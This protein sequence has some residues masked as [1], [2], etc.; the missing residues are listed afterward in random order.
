MALSS[1]LT[2]GAS[3]ARSFASSLRSRRP[4]RPLPAGWPR[5]LRLSMC[6]FR[7]LDQSL[8]RRFR[9]RD[10]ASRASRDRDLERVRDL[11]GGREPEAEAERE[12]E[13]SLGSSGGGCQIVPSWHIWK[14]SERQCR[15]PSPCAMAKAFQR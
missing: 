11:V 14:G 10:R 7:V 6:F 5:P 2:C 12:R 15:V 8:W 4:R 3:S 1:T 9:E 13:L